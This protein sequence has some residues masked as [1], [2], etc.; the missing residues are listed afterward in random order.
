MEQLAGAQ[1]V[2]SG[3]VAGGCSPSGVT[4]GG[5]GAAGEAETGA[6][7]ALSP[8]LLP[9]PGE[10]I[11]LSYAILRAGLYCPEK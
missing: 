1:R 10:N 3:D 2:S 4:G 11:R 6:E 8:A 5:R 9:S 7:H